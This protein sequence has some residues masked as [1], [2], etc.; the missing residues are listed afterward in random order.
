[1]YVVGIWYQT[2]LSEVYRPGNQLS[3]L[4]QGACSYHLDFHGMVNLSGWGPTSY[5]GVDRPQESHLLH[6][7]SYVESEAGSLIIFSRQLRLRNLVWTQH[8]TWESGCSLS[9]PSDDVDCQVSHCLLQP[10]QLRMFVTYMLHDDS[11]LHKIT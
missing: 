4:R 7:H 8:S 11:L 5:S 6:H 3:G 1:M 10:D 2:L 9:Y